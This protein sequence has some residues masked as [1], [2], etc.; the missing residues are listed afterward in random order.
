MSSSLERNEVIFP[1]PFC[2]LF[3]LNV[4]DGLT[5]SVMITKPGGLGEAEFLMKH[6]GASIVAN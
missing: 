4:V 6:T 1:F 5:Y 3:F 2:P